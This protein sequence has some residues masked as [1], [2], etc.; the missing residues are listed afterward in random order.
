MDWLT[1]SDR[2]E[3]E[4]R[5]QFEAL[6]DIEELSIV[7]LPS[8]GLRY[9][10]TQVR[11]GLVA[12]HIVEDAAIRTRGIDR[13]V[14]GQAARGRRR[15]RWVVRQRIRVE[16]LADA[17]SLTVSTWGRPVG[18]TLARHLLLGGNDTTTGRILTEEAARLSDSVV[19]GVAGHFTTLRGTER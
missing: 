8:G 7:R 17:V 10:S 19:D 12:R 5:R 6:E 18:W 13:V 1:D 15:S 3:R 14:R 2:R 11:A 4:L 16:S 9:E